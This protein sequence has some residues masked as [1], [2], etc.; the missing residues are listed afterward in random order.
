MCDLQ[1]VARQGGDEDDNELPFRRADGTIIDMNNRSKWALIKGRTE[2]TLDELL[3]VGDP[4][5]V[6]CQTH[7][8][9]TGRGNTPSCTWSVPSENQ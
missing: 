1:T 2:E 3:K 6:E 9:G 8:G 7:E 4:G 5:G